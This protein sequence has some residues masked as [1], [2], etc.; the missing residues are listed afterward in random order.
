LLGEDLRGEALPSG[1]THSLQDGFARRHKLAVLVNEEQLL[2][3]AQGEGRRVTE[4]MGV[5]QRGAITLA[6]RGVFH[7]GESSLKK[8][9]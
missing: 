4:M 3:Y 6:M 1:A 9:I 5:A 8:L 7:C 2:L